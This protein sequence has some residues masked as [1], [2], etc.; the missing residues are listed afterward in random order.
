MALTKKELR[1]EGIS[2]TRAQIAKRALEIA[3][4]CISDG[5]YKNAIGC[6][7]RMV[8]L[9][10]CIDDCY[11]DEKMSIGNRYESSYLLSSMEADYPA[12][13]VVK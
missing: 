5:S 11:W 7:G 1:K 6:I 12:N 2:Y 13:K 3:E 4:L 9:S 10:K 8:A